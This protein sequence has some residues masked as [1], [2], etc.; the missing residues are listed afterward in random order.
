MLD[1]RIENLKKTMRRKPRTDRLDVK[2]RHPSLASVEGWY[3][4]DADLNGLPVKYKPLVKQYVESGDRMKFTRWLAKHELLTQKELVE[5]GPLL[6]PVDFK[7]SCRHNDLLRLAETSHYKSCFKN[8]RGVQQLRYL[9]D[10]DIGVVY[11]PDKAGKFVWRAL[12]RLMQD[13]NYLEK[14][15]F[16]LYK[17]YGNSNTYAICKKLNSIYPLYIQGERHQIHNWRRGVWST[18]E[19]N[20]LVLSSA[21][22]HDNSIVSK[23]VW[24]DHW[25]ALDPETSRLQMCGKL[26]EKS[27]YI[28]EAEL[29]F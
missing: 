27:V 26:W 12:I 2:G 24:S 19:D 13:P 7:I 8:W 10:P 9:A 6:K 22:K 25:C 28:N 17:G 5:L 14:Y 21:S 18:K 3:Q 20:S 15:V 23:H 29:P 1:Q 4:V 16:F 11:V